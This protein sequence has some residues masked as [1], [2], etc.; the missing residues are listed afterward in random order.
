MGHHIDVDDY[1][2]SLPEPTRAIGTELREM[3]DIA[4][5]LGAGVLWH[6]HPVWMSGKAPLAGFK[7]YA[8]H[9]TLM[10]WNGSGITD[11]TGRLVHGR[12]MSTVRIR[13]TSDIDHGLFTGWL[14]STRSA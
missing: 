1:L 4:L 2:S 3:L 8:A 6:G 9:V 7:A 14:L 13:A 10:I 11:R 12:H 5:P